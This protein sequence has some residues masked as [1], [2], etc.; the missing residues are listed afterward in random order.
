[1]KTK[2]FSEYIETPA[3]A[4]PVVGTSLKFS[5]RM[6]S[7]KVLL[8]IGR[9][10]YTV[11]PGLYAVGTPG[12]DSPVFVS[13]NYKYSFDILRSHLAGMVCWILVLDTKGINVWCAAGKGSFGTDELVRQIDKTGLLGIVNHKKII[14]PQLGAP[15]VSAQEVKRQS[16]FTVIYGP[17]R[18]QDIRQFID[19][20]YS[21]DEKM[22]LIGFSFYNRLKLIPVELTGLIKYAFY[23]L[24]LVFLV[25]GISKNGFDFYRAFSGMRLPAIFLAVIA[26]GGIIF[27][28]MFLPLI[29]FRS[30]AVKGAITGFLLS[31]SAVF[32]LDL[33]LIHRLSWVFTATAL[34]SFLFLNFTGAS[35]YTSLSGVVKEMTWAVPL[36]IVFFLAGTSLFV[37]GLF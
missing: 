8:N 11:D 33:V 26:L 15:G 25:S 19:N 37:I 34:S 12:P 31:I 2:L 16:G 13:A 3:G 36:H 32:F 24:A 23:I 27:P 29:P 22:R 17:V 20:N 35:T 30:F 1:M 7:L 21:A 9:M 14:V 28:T 4:V 5:D 18:A 6:G 10:D